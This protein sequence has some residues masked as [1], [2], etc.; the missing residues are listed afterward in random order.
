MYCRICRG[1]FR[2]GIDECPVCGEPLISRLPAK[3]TRPGVARLPAAATLGIAGTALMFIIRTI[4]TFVPAPDLIVA[5]VMSSL[6]LLSYVAVIAFFV[7]FLAE[8]VNQT[9]LRLKV[10]T[11]LALAGCVAAAAIVALNL[12]V[13]FDRPIVF[14]HPLG[15]A[16]T[17]VSILLPVTSAVFFAAFLADR[18]SL[19][20]RVMKAARFALIGALVSAA[21]HAVAAVLI[22]GVSTSSLDVSVLPALVGL[23]IVLF[24]VGT[25]LTFLWTIRKAGST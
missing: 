2:D 18:G 17:V 9:Q 1:E 7:V 4:S 22:G 6:Y 15:A 11:C 20:S 24:A 13:L 25:W 5:R 21:A 10:A 23:P 14:A 12:L 8:A 16:S 3:E 19:S